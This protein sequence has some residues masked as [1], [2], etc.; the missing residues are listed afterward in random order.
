MNDEFVTLSDVRYLDIPAD[1]ILEAARG[2]LNDVVIIGTHKDG[3]EYFAS[4][5]ADGPN[6]NWMLDRAKKA[7]V[8]IVDEKENQKDR[9]V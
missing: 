6:V 8:E 9:V 7:L 4:S 5:V 2:E 3:T 1:R